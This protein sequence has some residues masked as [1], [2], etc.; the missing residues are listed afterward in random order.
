MAVPESPIPLAMVGQM[1]DALKWQ[2]IATLTAAIITA[3][4]KPHS[5]QQ[6]LDIANDFHFA[7]FPNPNFG[8]Y[9]EW[10]KFKDARLSR[11]HGTT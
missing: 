5:I 10:E 1:T 9:R 3:S 7:M 8:A 2:P 11:V 4:G 6:T